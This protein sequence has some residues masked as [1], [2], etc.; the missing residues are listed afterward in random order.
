MRNRPAPVTCDRPDPSDHKL[1]TAMLHG[2]VAIGQI[3]PDD[4]TA[5]PAP[6]QPALR[7]QMTS[8]SRSL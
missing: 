8:N 2:D 6:D 1:A 7:S 5:S 3:S 4:A